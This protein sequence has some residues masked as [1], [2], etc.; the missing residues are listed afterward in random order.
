[1]NTF[2]YGDWQHRTMEI[3]FEDSKRFWAILKLPSV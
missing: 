3:S 1:M 2:Y